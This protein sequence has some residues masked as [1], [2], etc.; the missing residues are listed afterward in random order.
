MIPN[1]SEQNEMLFMNI[2]FRLSAKWLRYI[3]FQVSNSRQSIIIIS[4]FGAFRS[5]LTHFFLPFQSLMVAPSAR[6]FNFLIYGKCSSILDIKSQWINIDLEYEQLIHLSI[7]FK[8]YLKA[9]IRI[10][11]IALGMS[12]NNSILNHVPLQLFD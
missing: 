1:V 8:L 3:T 10:K 12:T 5:E 9:V 7:S 2:S 6:S 11:V 4:V